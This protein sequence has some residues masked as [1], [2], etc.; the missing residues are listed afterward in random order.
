MRLAL[1]MILRRAGLALLIA[2]LCA[3]AA[4]A[5]REGLRIATW[6]VDLNRSGPGL[7]LAELDRFDPAKSAKDSQIA[8]IFE[9]LRALDADVVVLTGV[10]YDAGQRTL[11]ALGARLDAAELPYPWL[12]ALPPNSGIPTGLDLDRDGR[13]GGAR[14][15]MGYGRFRGED[16]IAL[17]SRLPLDPNSAQD[18]TGFLWKDL[19]QALIPPDT[20]AGELALQRLSSVNH[21]QVAVQL[22]DGGR[23]GLLTWAATPPV[24]DGPEDRNGR[25]NHDEAAFWLHLLDGA[26]PFPAPEP[27][28]VILGD[29]NLD[30]EDGDGR[31]EALRRLLGDPRLQDLAPRGDHGRTEPGHK[32]DPALDTA[33][34]PKGP[35]GLRVDYLL[36]SAG[37]RVLDAGVLWPAAGPLAETLALA[38]RHAPV[39]A[40]IALP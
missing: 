7:L 11:A 1:R 23:L 31:P 8:A 12:F 19:P 26:L 25:R 16:G 33:Y 39:W 10:D 5:G 37:L 21:W 34:F 30:P 4:R 14:D 24:F 15:A 3:P 38:S 2:A 22:P 32:G 40:D 13:L 36:P 6:H 17:L 29:A 27:P 18:Y 9:I 28:F 20:S 35:G